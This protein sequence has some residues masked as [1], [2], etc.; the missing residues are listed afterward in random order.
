M[1][2]LAHILGQRLE[3]QQ[4]PN[5][6]S[7]RYLLNNQIASSK[8]RMSWFDYYGFGHS[9]EDYPTWKC[10]LKNTFYFFLFRSC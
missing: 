7:A 5:Q 2:Q 8:F 4:Q 10:T 1:N 3:Q 9:T 6:V